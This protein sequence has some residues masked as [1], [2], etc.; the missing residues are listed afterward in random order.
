MNL[1]NYLGAY[2]G[3]GINHEDQKFISEFSL[4]SI[5]NGKGYRVHF[6]A[7]GLDGTI[8]H[9]EESVIAPSF[10]GK[11]HLFNLNTNIPALVEHELRRE[12]RMDSSI[13]YIFGF[14][15][16]DDLKSFREEIKLELISNFEIGYWYSW[17][18]PGGDF[19]LRS[20]AR[21]KKINL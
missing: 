3:D 13:V 6:R 5:L 2:R 18:L 9:E 21:M 17:G 7:T 12:E 4:A 11:F 16:T 19:K 20:G 15:K 10:S 14:N 8:Y 1:Q